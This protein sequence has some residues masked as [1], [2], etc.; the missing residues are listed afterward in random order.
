MIVFQIEPVVE[1]AND[2]SE[3][4]IFPQP[5]ALDSKITCHALSPDFLVYGNDVSLVIRVSNIDSC[6]QLLTKF[7]TVSS[8]DGPNS[9]LLL[10][11]VRSI[12]RFYT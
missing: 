5:D 7:V 12:Y 9:L 3:S 2:R 1:S 4:K 11:S 6:K 10:G 8:S